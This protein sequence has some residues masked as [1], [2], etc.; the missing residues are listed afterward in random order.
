MTSGSSRHILK[1]HVTLLPFIIC[2]GNYVNS[3]HYLV[4]TA[5]GSDESGTL[6]AITKTSKQCGCNILESKLTLM[7]E[8]CAML[9]HF[10]GAWNTIAKLEATLPALCQQLGVSLQMKRTMPRKESPSVPYNVQ[11]TAHDRAG[12][13]NELAFFF[14]QNRINVDKLECE[15][16][17]ARNNS[18]L[19]SID[20]TIH[21]PA[22][23]SLSELRER[24]MVYCDER[25]LDAV[26]EPQRLL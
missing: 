4:V 10:S 1:N 16:Y 25:N 3:Q 8:E 20:L 5:L 6:E 17:T 13:L 19:T 24:F 7:G 21:I 9:F 14:L 18:Q 15:T 11:V 12:I 22:K 23:R 26:I 2:R